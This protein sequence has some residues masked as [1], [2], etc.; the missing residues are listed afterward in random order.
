MK[1]FRIAALAAVVFFAAACSSDATSVKGVLT[2]TSG[3][4]IVVKMFDVGKMS[5]IDTVKTGKDGKFKFKVPIKKGDPD[6]VYLY[7]HNTRVASLLL[8]AGEKVVVEADTLGHYTV[9]GSDGSSKF[10]EVE[11]RF[12]EFMQEF[13]KIEDPSMLVRKFREYNRESNIYVGKNPSSLTVIPVLL[14]ETNLG[15]VFPLPTDALIFRIA[16]DSLKA[17]YPDSRLVKMLEQKTTE[18]ELVLAYNTATPVGYLDFEMDDVNCKKVSLSSVVA[19]SKVVL[20]NFWTS[21]DPL[22]N[23]FNGEVL[24]PIYDDYHSRGLDIYSVC[25]DPDKS[26]WSSVVKGQEM[27]WVNVNDG[28]GSKS[29]VVGLYNLQ[30]L[31]TTI[32]I[33]NGE[34]TAADFDSEIA[35]RE[36]LERLLK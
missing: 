22:Q 30:S 29:P 12:S 34:V 7:Y 1:N 2:G 14:R 27:P 8:E 4:D 24:R 18:R 17:V 32:V 16:C 35:L 23:R 20:L 15:P 21:S 26:Y 28:L 10:K 3:A 36:E 19:K 31:P 33:G 11:D 25:L 6:F 13:S 5:V 9:S